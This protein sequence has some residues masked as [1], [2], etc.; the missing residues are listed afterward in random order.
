MDRFSL[1]QECD[2]VTDCIECGEE[3]WL[4]EH[5]IA[6]EEEEFCSLDCCI[7]WLVSREIVVEKN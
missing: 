4:D 7:D 5:H 2:R 6:Y 3:I 1:P